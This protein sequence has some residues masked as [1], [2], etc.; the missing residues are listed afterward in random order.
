MCIAM[1]QNQAKNIDVPEGELDL[2]RERIAALPDVRRGKSPEVGGGMDFGA[3][4]VD[5]L[6]QATR[7]KAMKTSVIQGAA[8]L[9]TRATKAYP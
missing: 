7:P 2:A 6:P 1:L 5:E 4:G 9:A 8:M 3:R